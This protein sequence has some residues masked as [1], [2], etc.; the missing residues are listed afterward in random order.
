MQH[1]AITR[2]NGRPVEVPVEQ[3]G[4]ILVDVLCQLA[5]IGRDR[6]LVLQQSDGTNQVVP[7][8][9]K[10]KVRPNTQFVDAPIH[11]RGRQSCP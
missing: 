4:S 1:H 2:V 5:S 9:H 10:M 8:G 6:T 7:R 3:D 11:R